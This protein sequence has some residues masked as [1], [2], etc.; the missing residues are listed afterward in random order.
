MAGNQLQT[1][2]AHNMHARVH[3]VLSPPAV[4]SVQHRCFG[5]LV[6]RAQVF[7]HTETVKWLRISW[8]PRM[9]FRAFEGFWA[10]LGWV[11]RVYAWTCDGVRVHAWSRVH[12]SA[13]AWGGRMHAYGACMCVSGWAQ[14]GESLARCE[15]GGRLARCE[16]GGSV[17]SLAPI[18]FLWG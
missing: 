2:C 5:Q 18:R 3:A 1:A 14:V 12:M 7:K 11:D 9:A 16:T 13:C 4:A 8:H 10:Q 15:A 17:A 6:A